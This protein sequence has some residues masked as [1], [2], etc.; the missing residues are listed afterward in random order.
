MND[1]F[2]IRKDDKTPR[3]LS[4]TLDKKAQELLNKEFLSSKENFLHKDITEYIEEDGKKV[5]VTKTSPLEI[6]PYSIGYESNDELSRIT[7]FSLDLKILEAIDNPTNVTKFDTENHSF[8]EIIAI[9]TADESGNILVQNYNSANVIQMSKTIW[10]AEDTKQMTSG[11]IKGFKINDKLLAII[12]KNG[13]E[14]N[15]VFKNFNMTKRVF[16]NLNSYFEYA[17]DPILKNF[18]SRHF[19]LSN[20]FDI[21]EIANNETRKKLAIIEK[22]EILTKEEPKRDELGNEMIDD[23][24]KVILEKK[25]MTPLEIKD[26]A[27]KFDFDLSL[28]ED[29]S[30]ILAPDNTKE[31]NEL[32]S[33]LCS[34]IYPSP[35]TGQRM[36]ANAAR[37]YPKKSK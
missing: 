10:I 8:E 22:L 5:K 32:L 29:E 16:K 18:S 20:N 14:L 12:E 26:L 17:S 9:F 23:N 1:Y 19:D 31:L 36:K 7:D 4:L 11:N 13:K 37:P 33:G 34:L 15:L 2:I 30:K 25:E 27:K 24:G 21:L 3:I 35:I 6:I 28:T